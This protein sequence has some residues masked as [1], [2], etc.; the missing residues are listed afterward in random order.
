MFDHDIREIPSPLAPPLPARP[1]VK[2]PKP[3]VAT[4]PG[5]HEDLPLAIAVEELR[6]LPVPQRNLLLGHLMA[7][8]KMHPAYCAVVAIHV[9]P[10]LSDAQ[11]AILCGKSERQLRR[12]IE[13]Q[14]IKPDVADAQDHLRQQSYMDAELDE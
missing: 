9:Q 3:V 6:K 11:V 14:K 1:H 5:L 13:Y 4:I 7:L 12:Y 2:P 10:Y 8:L